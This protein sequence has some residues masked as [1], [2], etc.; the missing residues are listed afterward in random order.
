MNRSNIIVL[1]CIIL[2]IVLAGL[3]TYTIKQR[4]AKATIDASEAGTALKTESGNTAYTDIDGNPVA[5]DDYLGNVLIVNSWAS[6][7]PFSVNELPSFA[8]LGQEFIDSD[9]K[10]LA[11]NRAESGATAQAFLR[12]VE[13]TDGLLLI[14][15]PGD[16]YYDSIEGFSMPETIFYDVKGNIVHHKRGFMTYEEMRRLTLK[17]LEQ[18]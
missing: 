16:R 5:L 12:S 11:I 8:R 2:I 4:N 14:L 17:T 7:S 10:V 13:A 3:F 9:V 18:Q 15:D 1:V 6:W